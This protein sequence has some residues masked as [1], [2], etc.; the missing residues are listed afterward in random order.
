VAPN[1]E[2]LKAA[3]RDEVAPLVARDK[4]ELYLVGESPERVHVHL[5]GV[6]AGCPGATLTEEYLIAPVVRTVHPGATVVV[7]NGASAPQGAVRIDAA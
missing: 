1:P 3:L 7:T 4:G 2:R 6:C 5:G